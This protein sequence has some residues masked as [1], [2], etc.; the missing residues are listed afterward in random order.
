MKKT[1]T[2]RRVLLASL[3]GLVMP[4]V[5]VMLRHAYETNPEQTPFLHN[6]ILVIASAWLGGLGPGLLATLSH[7][8]AVGIW[9]I[10]PT[11]ANWLGFVLVFV[12]G[13]LLACFGEARLRAV[14]RWQKLTSELE[15]RV[16]ER[17]AAL[18]T[19]NARLEQ[20]A[21]ERE[22]AIAELT[23][24]GRQLQASNRELETF[25][26]VAS[27]DLQEPLRKIRTFSDRLMQRHASGLDPE[28]RDYLARS[29][30]AAERMSKLIDDLLTYSH[31]TTRAKPRV[32]VDL[33]E[34]VAGV[35]SDLESRIADSGARVEVEP[36]PTFLA[37]PAQMRQL[38]ENLIVN[39]LKFVAPGQAPDVLVTGR[40][41][42]RG[43][44][45]VCVMSV[46]DRGIGIEERHRGKI[47]EMFQ[48]LHGRDAYEGTGIG[49]AICRKIAE[50][51]GGEIDVHER[52]DGGTIFTVTV[53]VSPPAEEARDA[54]FG[55]VRRPDELGQEA[56]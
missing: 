4:F 17:T 13:A 32:P 22:R 50:R 27:H 9:I 37:D 35:V 28:G 45:R 44:S 43:E 41:E 48:R 34:V 1:L 6:G 38:F 10:P 52:P 25:A 53:P 42:T 36:L 8:T 31:V 54:A 14:A 49:L 7:L 20:E 40:I 21:A 29:V 47:F 26:S 33:S 56:G 12:Q 19:S 5:V 2:R 30:N 23:S 46:A 3:L 39:A 55:A 51:H 16:A 15:M 11:A 24:A 18:A